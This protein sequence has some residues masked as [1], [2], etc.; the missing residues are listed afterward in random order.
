MTPR[1]SAQ[2]ESWPPQSV[3][4]AE[5]STLDR[6]TKWT[7]TAVSRRVLLK[8]AA[9]AAAAALGLRLLDVLPAAAYDPNLC[10][11]ACDTCYSQTGACC[12][13]NGQH[14]YYAWCDCRPSCG[15]YNPSFPFFRARVTVYN[16]GAWGHSCCAPCSSC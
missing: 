15:C 12:S 3:E 7:A 4:T 6:F 16:S 2:R 13:D 9:A 1:D 10:Y 14:C 11:G 5:L 8:R